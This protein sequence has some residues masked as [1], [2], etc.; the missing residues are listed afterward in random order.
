[1]TYD[2][3][4]GRSTEAPWDFEW[5]IDSCTS[6][7]CS[8]TCPK[9]IIVFHGFSPY[10]PQS[11]A[12]GSAYQVPTGRAERRG[13]LSSWIFDQNRQDGMWGSRITYIW[14]LQSGT[15]GAFGDLLENATF[16]P[17]DAGL[18]VATA[19]KEHSRCHS[20]CFFEA[21]RQGSKTP[22]IWSETGCRW[23]SRTV[24]SGT[25]EDCELHLALQKRKEMG[26]VE[27]HLPQVKDQQADIFC[28]CRFFFFF[29]KCPNMGTAKKP[30][31][32][33]HSGL[34]QSGVGLHRH[35]GWRMG[36]LAFKSGSQISFDLFSVVM[37][38]PCE[39]VAL[40]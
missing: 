10:Y 32:G 28:A 25:V 33:K 36:L 31:V 40:T 15:A 35:G 18:A 7:C 34:V 4:Q 13:A 3:A 14:L 27:R 20:R 19:G 9:K 26:Q 22:W 30:T 5:D 12:D 17:L 29:S 11:T 2:L 1:M 6:F 39:V 23:I 38:S 21:P 16:P 24:W 8:K 37:F